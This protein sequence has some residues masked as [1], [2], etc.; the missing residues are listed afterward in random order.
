MISDFQLLGATTRNLVGLVQLGGPDA[1]VAEQRLLS[2][3]DTLIKALARQASGDSAVLRD[4]LVLQQARAAFSDA[5]RSYDCAGSGSLSTHFCAVMRTAMMAATAGAVRANE[6][7]LSVFGTLP[8]SEVNYLIG[9]N[10]W[11]LLRRIGVK[12]A[13]IT[14]A[15]GAAKQT[16]KHHALSA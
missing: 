16:P 7:Q 13:R 9:R 5:L 1:V 6:R 3:N 2:S 15:R 12:D 10:D 11:Q 4:N 8:V 14:R